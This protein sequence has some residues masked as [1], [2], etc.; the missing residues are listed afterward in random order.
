[1]YSRP[2]IFGAILCINVFLQF[3]TGVAVW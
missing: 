3:R 1:V 2:T